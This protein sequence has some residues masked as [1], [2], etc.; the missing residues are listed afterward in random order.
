[1]TLESEIVEDVPPVSRKRVTISM[2]PKLLDWVDELV[3]EKVE[4]RDRS[5]LIEIAIT[6][7]REAQKA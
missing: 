2:E 4:Y 3:K 1:M 6:R 5:H 7:Y